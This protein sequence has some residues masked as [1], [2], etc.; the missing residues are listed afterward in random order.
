MM[1]VAVFRYGYWELNLAWDVQKIECACMIIWP[2]MNQKHLAVTKI[3]HLVEDITLT[4]R[5]S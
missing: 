1:H 3:R 5:G 2:N 4:I